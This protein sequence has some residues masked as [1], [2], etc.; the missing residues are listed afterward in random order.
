MGVILDFDLEK[1]EEG[2]SGTKKRWLAG[3][4][5]ALWRL[6]QHR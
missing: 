4:R 5:E 3:G 6:V 2:G 1:G